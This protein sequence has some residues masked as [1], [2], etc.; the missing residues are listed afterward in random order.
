[1]GK[2]FYCFFSLLLVASCS[3][4]NGQIIG[5]EEKVYNEIF[6]QFQAHAGRSNTPNTG[7][8]DLRPQWGV[9]AV[10]GRS[11]ESK[12][13]SWVRVLNRP[14]TGLCIGRTHLGNEGHVGHA[15][16]L[17]PF[18]ETGLGRK[19]DSRWSASLGFGAS[20]ISQKY[21]ATSNAN[22]R[23][24]STHMNWTYRSFLY[25]K[26]VQGAVFDWRMGVGY[27]HHSNGHTRL[28][29]QGIN[30]F[31]VSLSTELHPKRTNQE[32]FAQEA[33]EPFQQF[34]LRIG[35][36]HNIFSLE[37]NEL[38]NVHSVVF[39][40]GLVWKGVFRL[41][42]NA[43]FRQYQHYQ[44][45]IKADNEL[46]SHSYAHMKDNAF[47][48][49]MAIGL[50]LESE[51]IMGHIGA[52]L[53]VGVNV[54]KPAYELDWKLNEGH[55]D[56]YKDEF[57]YGE[58]NWYYHIKHRMS[59]RLAL[60]YYLVHYE[61]QPKINA[62]VSAALNANLGQADFSELSLGLIHRISKASR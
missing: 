57:I 23:A 34:G 25:W 56:M 15:Y 53:D 55:Y 43:Y 10:I 20:Y 5:S 54:F 24:I 31:L 50:G 1:M 12:S 60:N 44:D 22:N 49:A 37:E 4:L 3:M 39:R 52:E 29:N 27:I 9:S 14:K 51:F 6:T 33:T 42:A 46:V 45:Y 40:Y 7:F 38:K 30:S 32:P 19:T 17:M 47:L 16:A 28:P 26:I 18:I 21:H 35:R 61:K 58:L 36:G 48:N 59:S 62:Y 13:L 2:P 8:P 41:G 11:W